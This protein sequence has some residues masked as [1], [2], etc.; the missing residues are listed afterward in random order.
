MTT[1]YVVKQGD[2]DEVIWFYLLHMLFGRGTLLYLIPALIFGAITGLLITE[3]WWW[4]TFFGSAF[5]VSVLNFFC[6]HNQENRNH[7][8]RWQQA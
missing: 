7:L 8:F 6:G 5:T 3:S 4:T 1:K 2:M